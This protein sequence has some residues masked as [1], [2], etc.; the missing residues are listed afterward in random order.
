MRITLIAMHFAEYACR[1]A[2]ALA[3]NHNVQLILS[4]PNVTAELENE[5]DRFRSIPQLTVVLLDHTRSPILW[6][7]NTIIL[8]RQIQ[9]FKPDIIHQQENTRDY[10]VA[11]LIYLSQFFPF[12][13]TV[14]DPMPHSGQ[15]AQQYIR[16]R[17]RIYHWFLRKLCI[18]AITHGNL[19]R[20]QLVAIVPRLVERVA[21]IP[22]G[23]MGPLQVPEQEA[24]KPGTL[25]FF[26]RINA[27][28]GLRYFIDA[29]L[30]LKAKGFCV[31][32]II[33]GRGD[34]LSP[35]RVAI[36]SNDCFE[37]HDE[38]ISRAKVHALFA[39]AYLVVMPYTDATQSGVAAM[40][41]GFGCPVVATRVGSIPEMVLDGVT[42]LLVPPCD[43]IALAEAI[44]T[45]LSNPDHYSIL[46]SNVRAA[47]HGGIMTWESIASS[48]SAVYVDVIENLRVL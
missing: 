37:L 28:K 23:P 34:D 10:E 40:A 25:L 46:S 45:L 13:L 15:D 33:A 38:Y 29:T 5:F 36:E 11:A 32:G 27:Y 9:C 42:G 18:R 22:H 35:N 41:I 17:H 16:S 14:H 20:E 48:T 47:G 12:I 39:R 8:V 30:Q 6:V 43:S 21:V 1:L 31:K 7:K 24:P 3:C 4:R 2:E 26:G 19:L 44:E